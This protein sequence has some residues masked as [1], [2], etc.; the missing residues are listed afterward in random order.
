MN[1]DYLVDQIR[2]V[3]DYLTRART[4]SQH[5]RNEFLS[6]YLLSDAAIRELTV[7]FETCHNIA[8]HLIAELGWRP[9]KSKAEAFEVLSEHDVIPTELCNAFREASRFRNLATYQTSV[10]D[11][12]IVYEVLT[13]HLVDFEQ[14]A[15][16]VA[17]WIQKNA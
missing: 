4:I 9:P 12:S 5:P 15:V 6:E 14:F 2:L 7:L 16:R 17:E 13:K 1:Q 10:V 3:Q 8:K 11:V